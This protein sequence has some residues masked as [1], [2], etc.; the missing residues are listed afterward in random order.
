VTAG[1]TTR[2]SLASLACRRI[3]CR[4][5]EGSPEVVRLQIWFGSFV[6]FGVTCH[7]QAPRAGM[8]R[9]PSSCPTNKPPNCKLPQ[10]PVCQAHQSGIVSVA[11]TPYT[12]NVVCRVLASTVVRKPL[13]SY[14][15]NAAL[16][17]AQKPQIAASDHECSGNQGSFRSRICNDDRH[18]FD[19]SSMP[20]VHQGNVLIGSSWVVRRRHHSEP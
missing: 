1:A 2:R 7:G 16:R 20:G 19:W 14:G 18:A 9:P 8:V 13:P 4:R 3:R 5:G 6:R 15:S 11:L 10:S 17:K 12:S